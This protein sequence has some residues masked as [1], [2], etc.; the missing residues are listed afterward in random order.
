LAWITAEETSR[1]NFPAADARVLDRLR[2]NWQE[3]AHFN[4]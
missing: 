3:L 1:Y 2:Q 4:V